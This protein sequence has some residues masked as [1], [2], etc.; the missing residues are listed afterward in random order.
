MKHNKSTGTTADP[1]PIKLDRELDGELDGELISQ[2]V[3]FTVEELCRSCMLQSDQIV[4]LVQEGVLEAYGE[5][6]TR[7]RFRISS[8][9][10]VRTA[11]RLQ[12]DLGVN[13]AGAALALELLDRIA[14]L[15]RSKSG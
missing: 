9:R 12:R 4:E 14:E 13:L 15:E 1:S 6:T 11:M 3:E 2:E 10:R 5:D 7:W 8:F